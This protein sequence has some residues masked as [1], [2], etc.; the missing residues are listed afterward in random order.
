MDVWHE[1]FELDDVSLD[2]DV[3]ELGVD[4]MAAVE[5]CLRLERLFGVEITPAKLLIAPTVGRLAALIDESRQP[6]ARPVRRR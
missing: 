3:L 5:M 4:S 2:D 1:V 6:G